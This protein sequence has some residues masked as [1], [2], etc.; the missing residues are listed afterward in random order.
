[1]LDIIT[2]NNHVIK[3]NMSLIIPQEAEES[4]APRPLP[5]KADGEYILD[6]DSRVITRID[7]TIPVKEAMMIAK[8][9]ASAPSTLGVL[10]EVAENLANAAKQDEFSLHGTEGEDKTNCLIC[11]IDDYINSVIGDPDAQPEEPS[12]LIH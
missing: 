7:A 8:L 10:S 4:V 3:L 11:Q 6:A 5:F 9:L 2:K 12:T 1:M